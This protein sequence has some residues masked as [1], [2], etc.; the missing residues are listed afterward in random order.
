M[1]LIAMLHYAKLI[2]FYEIEMCEAVGQKKVKVLAFLPENCFYTAVCVNNRFEMSQEL[3]V[4][5]DIT[6]PQSDLKVLESFIV[7]AELLLILTD[8]LDAPSAASLL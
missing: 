3:R 2:L 7:H 8:C 4:D 5:W 6:E 1:A